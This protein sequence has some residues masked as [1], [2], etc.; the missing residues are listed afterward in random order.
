MA[1]IS[2]NWKVVDDIAAELGATDAQRLK[3]RQTG[4]GV[5]KEWQIKIVETLSARGQA[6]SFSDF[7]KL[8]GN[9]GRI[10]A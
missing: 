4:R 3:W 6:V 2:L 7:A 10:A 9:P 5:S 8:P 1:N